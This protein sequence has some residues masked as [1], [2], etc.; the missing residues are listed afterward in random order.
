MCAGPGSRREEP[1]ICDK[2]RAKAATSNAGVGP[3]P[4][5]WPHDGGVRSGGTTGKRDIIS[6][7]TVHV[8][9]VPAWR[10]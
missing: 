3:A 6:S 7:G 9:R 2:P 1:A 10:L 5:S 4:R 8:M